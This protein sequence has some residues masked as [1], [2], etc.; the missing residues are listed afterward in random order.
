[1]SHLEIYPPYKF[2]GLG[3]GK[4][5][6]V[7]T[8]SRIEDH[9]VVLQ[10][11]NSNNKVITAKGSRIILQG[12]NSHPITLSNDAT[13]TRHKYHG[14]I[15]LSATTRGALEVENLVSARDYITDVVASEAPLAAPIEMLKAQAILAQ[16]IL[17]KHGSAVIG[18]STERQ[19]YLGADLER[20]AIKAAV[21]DVW[22]RM[23]TYMKSP[24]I[25]YY[26]STCAGGTSDGSTY[27]HQPLGSLPYLTAVKCT[28]C[29][30]SPFWKTTRK[31]IPRSLFTRVFG[32]GVPEIL[33]SDDNF[34][35]LFIKLA[36]GTKLSGYDF[37]IKLG[38]SF[39]WDK[40]PGTRYS[41]EQ[42]KNKE[43]IIESSGAGHGV[44]LC[45]WGASALASKGRTYKEILHYYFPACNVK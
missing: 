33:Q 10:A 3:G 11:N 19:C 35:P 38:Q 2:T 13:G 5:I 6:S 28:Y 36:D 25:A 43:I 12:I 17:L 7:K 34:R 37:W 14:Q 40:A 41:L 1:M 9:K 4:T 27:F 26:H 31:S 45:Q 23:L 30:S 32:D 42:G 20:P 15:V 29:K 8:R 24:I 21:S 16:T 22:G 39:G 44:G 18:D